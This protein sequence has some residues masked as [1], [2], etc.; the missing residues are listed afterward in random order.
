MTANEVSPIEVHGGA[1][2]HVRLRAGEGG[3]PPVA[4]R[5][6]EGLPVELVFTP[7]QNHDTAGF[8]IVAE[9]PEGELRLCTGGLGPLT[10]GTPAAAVTTIHPSTELAGQ[11]V[12][13][14]F[15]VSGDDELEVSAR[16]AMAVTA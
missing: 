12:T 2:D 5:P 10:G 13:V 3:E 8:T 15:E 11:T 4:T 9:T 6:G 7:S 16:F 1:G 14:R